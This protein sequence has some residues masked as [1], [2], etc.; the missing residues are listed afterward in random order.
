MAS[1][2]LT[3][4][5][6]ALKQKYDQRFIQRI[7]YKDN[8]LLALMPKDTKFDGQNRVVALRYGTPQSRSA[9][10]SNVFGSNLAKTGKY[11]RFVITRNSDYA[12]AS[13]RGETIK[14]SENN[15]GALMRAVS[16]EIDG[17]L[18]SLQRSLA[19]SMY[20]NGG[21]S[22]GRVGSATNATTIT[23]SSVT[24]ITN[25]EVGMT[26]QGASTDGTSP[27]LFTGTAIVTGIDRIN[28]TLTTDASN[29]DTKISGLVNGSYLFA[30]GDFGQKITGLSGWLPTG[31]LSPTD[32]FFSVN[33]N[34][35]RTRLA[36]IDYTQGAGGPI[37]E[38]LI[39]A[40]S[41]VSREG[42]TIDYVFMNNLDR[43]NL[44]KALGSKV[45][46]NRVESNVAGISFK[47]IEIEGDKGPI[48][49][50]SDQNCPRGTAYGL[51]LDTWLLN[52]LGEAP[53][54]LD[55][56]GNKMLRESSSDAY[57]IRMGYYAQVSCDAP[58]YNVRITL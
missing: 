9:T 36:G 58:G 31:S 27:G 7:C 20:G 35:D 49:V 1:L 12:V 8:P 30:E 43:A 57:T 33:R 13:I 41:L 4:F 2:D 11:N 55:L 32:S 3:S 56:D 24:D 19:I 54:I 17:A 47:V 45:F 42:G 46:Y 52:S 25:F 5:A 40:V 39:D 38:T 26:L 44:I 28:G 16:E 6:A 21:G 22:L 18:H 48:K 23:L 29:W 15:S 34:A 51:Q 10:G 14:A 50:I 53:Q 37:E